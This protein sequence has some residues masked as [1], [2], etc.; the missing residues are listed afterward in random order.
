MITKELLDQHYNCR[1]CITELTLDKPDPLYVASQYKDE[2]IALICALFAYGNAHSIIK[3]LQTLDFDLLKSDE[4][5]IKN[6]LQNHY[7][8][9]QNANDVIALFITLNRIA[10]ENSLENI[11]HIGY[12]KEQSILDGIESLINKF[13]QINNYNSQGYNFLIGS[14]LKRDKDN[15]IKYNQNGAYKRWNMYLRW[16]VRKDCLDMGLWK[17]IDT[18][19]LLIPLDTHTFNVSKKIGL[20]KRKTYDLQAVIELTDKLKEFDPNDPVKYDF[21]LYRIGQEKTEV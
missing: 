20:L 1:N 6:Q 18:K 12:K 13:N 16:M 7:Y 8:R 19:D 3:F 14:P 15:K 11:F 10:R 2:S 17:D 21:A 9:F 5:M 4:Q